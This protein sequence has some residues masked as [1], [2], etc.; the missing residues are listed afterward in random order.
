MYS[1]FAHFANSFIFFKVEFMETFNELINLCMLWKTFFFS[2]TKNSQLVIDIPSPP[3]PAIPTWTLPLTS[4]HS[5]QKH[6]V[7]QELT[8]HKYTCSSCCKENLKPI[9][10]IHNHQTFVHKSL[11]HNKVVWFVSKWDFKIYM[12]KNSK[13]LNK[14]CKSTNI[15]NK[16]LLETCHEIQLVAM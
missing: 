8:N 6:V 15:G 3:S 14:M 1:K 11:Q 5:M 4:I 12:C 10:F 9:W 7:H 2:F 16:Y 13:S